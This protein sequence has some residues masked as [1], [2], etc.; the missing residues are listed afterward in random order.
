M[1]AVGIAPT[2]PKAY[3]PDGESIAE[4]RRHAFVADRGSGDTGLEDPEIAVWGARRCHHA[5]GSSAP[6]RCRLH[7]PC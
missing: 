7:W 6:G 4:L 1:Q 3:D 2:G 5:S